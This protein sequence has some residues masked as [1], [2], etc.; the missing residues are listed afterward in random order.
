MFLKDHLKEAYQKVPL[1]KNHLVLNNV[2]D[3]WAHRFGV[4][5]M[6]ELIFKPQDQ[7]NLLKE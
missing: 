2:I 3:K 4:E 7:F 1:Y 5:S 6:N